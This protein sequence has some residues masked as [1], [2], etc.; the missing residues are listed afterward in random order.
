MNTWLA[1]YIK[2]LKANKNL[3]LF[4]L[5]L[6]LG[7]NVYGLMGMTE[8][9]QG[10]FTDGNLPAGIILPTLGAFMLVISLPFLLAHAFNAEWKS[11]TH[12]QMFAL[13]V[14]QYVISLAK[15]AAI[16]T[17]GVVGGVLV[18]GSLYLLL[19]RVS[20]LMGKVVPVSISDFFFLG[21]FGF[22][23]YMVFVFGLV[24]GMEGVKYSV[25][26]YRGLASVVFVFGAMYLFARFAHQ[27]T[28]ALGFLGKIP[29]QFLSD[30]A[31]I[32]YSGIG[33]APFAYTILSGII[34]MVIGLVVYEKRAEI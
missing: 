7:L 25:K 32:T 19:E 6:I 11:E 15:I 9:S 30:N 34:L 24:A 29:I 2:D 31:T 17:V 13:P 10:N 14:P 33:V 22:M 1:L 18:I 23:A 3:S 8:V 16:G 27:A 28:E 21:S 20:S 26:R 5:V 4:L 12:Y